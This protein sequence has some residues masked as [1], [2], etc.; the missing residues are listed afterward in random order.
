MNKVI[1]IWPILRLRVRTRQKRRIAFDFLLI[2]DLLYHPDFVI[3]AKPLVICKS[4][5]IFL[6]EQSSRWKNSLRWRLA[7]HSSSY[8]VSSSAACQLW[9]WLRYR[10]S[11]L[12]LILMTR[13]HFTKTILPTPLRHFSWIPIFHLNCIHQSIIDIWIFHLYFLFISK[14]Q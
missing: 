9:R 7:L 12:P 5:Q 11:N 1:R 8:I 10:V 13:K 4:R 2:W 3:C 14:E 6:Y